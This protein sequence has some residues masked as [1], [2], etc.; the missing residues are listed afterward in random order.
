MDRGPIRSMYASGE[1]PLEIYLIVA[2]CLAA[3][4][5]A[6]FALWG[7]REICR[8]RRAQK[9]LSAEIGALK[10]D[11]GEL[12]Q[13]LRREMEKQRHMLSEGLNALGDS[14]AI[15]ALNAGKPKK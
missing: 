9:E 3:L 1:V 2:A 7:W 10:R 11:V 13:S 8:L 12:Q 4:A 6:L 5:G 15:S 14:I